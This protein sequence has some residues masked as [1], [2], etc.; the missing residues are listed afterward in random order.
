M[1]ALSMLGRGCGAVKHCFR[2]PQDGPDA[3]ASAL[4]EFRSKRPEEVLHIYPSQIRWYRLAEELR[5]RPPV[6]AVHYG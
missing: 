3:G 1:A 6:L 2:A 5:E 4:L